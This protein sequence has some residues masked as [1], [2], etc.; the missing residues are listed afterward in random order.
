MGR[1]KKR[2]NKQDGC[3]P[4]KNIFLAHVSYTCMSMLKKLH[5]EYKY[6]I[7]DGFYAKKN[8]HIPRYS[9]R[10]GR[11]ENVWLRGHNSLPADT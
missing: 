1:T 5:E 11:I 6:E 3:I 2:Q 4:I 8:V 10:V 9:S 7:H